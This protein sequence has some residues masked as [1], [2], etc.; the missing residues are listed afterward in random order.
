M[1]GEWVEL[2]SLEPITMWEPGCPL[3]I[4]KMTVV[5]N[6]TSGKLYLRATLLNI[7]AKETLAALL[8]AAPED[9]SEEKISLSVS[10]DKPCL[11][12]HSFI[13]MSKSIDNDILELKNC[14]IA[15]IQF[16]DKT[17]WTS[18]GNIEPIPLPEPLVL[19][20]K[21]MAQR[22][23]ELG[24]LYKG[25][26]DKIDASKSNKTVSDVAWWR[27]SCGVV[28]SGRDVCWNCGAKK[29]KLIPL[30]DEESLEKAAD[31]EAKS[32][33]E[34]IL[35]HQERKEKLLRN[36][37][38]IIGGSIAVVVV[39][40]LIVLIKAIFL[41]ISHMSAGDNAR[42]EGD[43]DTAISEYDAA[44]GF[45]E[46]DYYGAYTRCLKAVSQATGASAAL[47][48]LLDANYDL[49]N[50]VDEMLDLGKAY[51][52]IDDADDAVRCYQ[53][54]SEYADMSDSIFE[55]YKAAAESCMNSG[56]YVSAI[57]ILV[58][59]N[60]YG[61]S[62][63]LIY[64]DACEGA[65]KRLEQGKVDE[66]LALYKTADQYGDAK[67]NISYCESIKKLQSAENDFKAG[68]LSSAQSKFNE[69]P[70]DLTFKDVN[71]GQRQELLSSHQAFIDMCGNY[72]GSIHAKVTETS[73]NTGLTQW[74]EGDDDSATAEVSCKIADD[75]TV[76]VS[77]NVKFYRYTKFSV[78][79]A[80]LEGNSNKMS[81]SFETTELPN[82]V[83]IGDGTTISISEGSFTVNYYK[84]EDNRDIYFNYEYESSGTLS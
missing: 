14:E 24:K 53:A 54:V 66:A 69:L 75:G 81:F 47:S 64:K 16:S 55:A 2:R 62:N 80:G 52:G 82:S 29:A 43:W 40:V 59:A 5:K 18:S 7:G 36:K 21:A 10:A 33:Q 35:K 1:D 50:H 17:E 70:A 6:S 27:C 25:N 30:Q 23:K 20:E 31:E 38:K 26:K 39:I 51:L 13:A 83:N 12:G 67:N 46:A 32:K 9:S 34:K 61:D 84:Y 78:I 22:E 72:S 77:G 49:S 57:D 71:A 3:I 37:S 4:E 76:T 45:G 15:S 42:Q 63:D 58:L 79:S 74:W 73:K 28:N 44:N 41:P 11:P 8:L 19:S 65:E 48:A 56:M 60:D 68:K